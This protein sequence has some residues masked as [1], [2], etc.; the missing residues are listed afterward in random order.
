M[1]H[2]LRIM[3]KC[4]DTEDERNSKNYKRQGETTKKK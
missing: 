4:N 2:V 3:N 1:I